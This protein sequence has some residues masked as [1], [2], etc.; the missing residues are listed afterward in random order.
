M[1]F[2]V[3]WC[4]KS[5]FF[6][7]MIIL[8]YSLLLC[9]FSCCPFPLEV[10]QRY[11]CPIKRFWVPSVSLFLETSW[12]SEV[13]SDPTSAVEGS[14]ADTPL[15]GTG[16]SHRGPQQQQT[17]CPHIETHVTSLRRILAQ[18]WDPHLVGLPLGVLW[19]PGPM[20][21][22]RGAHCAQVSIYH[23]VIFKD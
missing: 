16:D 13:T 23:A 21:G 11:S 9:S 4:S 17:T 22:P 10:P 2:I 5:F 18:I 7:I 3:G 6:L 15:N 12:G 8:Y 19:F 20:E 14:S 1:K